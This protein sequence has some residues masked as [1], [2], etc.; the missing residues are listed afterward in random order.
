MTTTT[1]SM[2]TLDNVVLSNELVAVGHKR[3]V[4]L[5]KADLRAPRAKFDELFVKLSTLKPMW[6]FQIYDLTYDLKTIEGVK[7]LCQG[8]VLGIVK[9]GWFRNEYGFMV[10]N[11]RISASKQRRSVYC[12]HDMAKALAAIKKHFAPKNINERFGKA[13]EEALNLLNRQ[14]RDKEHKARQL[15]ASLRDLSFVF[16]NNVREQFIGFLEQSGKQHLLPEFE[17]R[18]AEML[19]LEHARKAFDSQDCAIVLRVDAQYIV[20]VRDKVEIFDDTTLPAWM[21]GKLGM[22]KLVEDENVISDVGCR[23]NPECFVLLLD[24]ETQGEGK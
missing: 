18:T 22:L 11:E 6:K 21:R 13:Q 23:V 2:L 1:L 19:T 9:W 3:G 5:S 16:A 12:T 20:K 7:I 10:G 4:T 24:A 15:H 8:E 17:Q 14:A